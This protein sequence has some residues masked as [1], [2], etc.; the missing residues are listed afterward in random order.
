MVSNPQRRQRVEYKKPGKINAVSISLLMFLSLLG[1]V[2]YCLWPSFHLSSEV[3]TLLRTE[4]ITWFHANLRPTAER[5]IKKRKIT[6]AL[7][8]ELRKK[9]VRDPELDLEIY[10]D[11]K[12]IWIEARYSTRVDWIWLNKTWDWKH[13]TRA[14]TS[15]ERVDW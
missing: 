6:D 14:E 7:T 11:K 9:G 15:A 3:S 8:L 13:T 2:G 1:Y 4:I 5:S 12:I 10:G